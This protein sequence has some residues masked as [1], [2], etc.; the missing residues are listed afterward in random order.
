M[1]APRML[2]DW[3]V[4]GRSCPLNPA[5]AVRWNHSLPFLRRLLAIPSAL[6]LWSI[7]PLSIPAVTIAVRIILFTLSTGCTTQRVYVAAWASPFYRLPFEQRASRIIR[8]AQ[9]Y[10]GC[11]T[12]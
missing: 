6:A 9:T 11:G 12:A 5:H 1:T 4:V 3:L 10:E 2:L 8:D 7:R